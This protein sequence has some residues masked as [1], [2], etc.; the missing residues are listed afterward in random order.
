MTKSYKQQLISKAV[1]QAQYEIEEIWWNYQNTEDQTNAL[2]DLMQANEEILIKLKT[3]KQLYQQRLK[4]LKD[5]K[6]IFGG[7]T[8]P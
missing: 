6:D 7:V 3:A 5:V 1:K 2:K 4:V 8:N